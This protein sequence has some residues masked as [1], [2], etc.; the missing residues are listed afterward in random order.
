MGMK[1]M[2]FIDG[3]RYRISHIPLLSFES[4]PSRQSKSKLNHSGLQPAAEA[5]VKD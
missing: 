4:A 2:V 1:E 3:S 5:R